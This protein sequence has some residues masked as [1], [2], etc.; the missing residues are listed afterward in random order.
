MR[1]ITLRIPDTQINFFL[2]LFEKLN[3]EPLEKEIYIPEK[4]KEIVRNRL[5][6]TS[7]KDYIPWKEARKKIK[8]KTK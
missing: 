3:I 1:E 8:F 2:E 7:P 4:H 5:I 6:N